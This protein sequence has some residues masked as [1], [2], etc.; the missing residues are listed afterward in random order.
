M[1]DAQQRE[2]RA[3]ASVDCEGVSDAEAALEASLS[4]S[5]DTEHVALA[6]FYQEMFRSG[7][8]RLHLATWPTQ[9]NL[10][11]LAEAEERLLIRGID[12]HYAVM[13]M[14][15]CPVYIELGNGRVMAKIAYGCS[16]DLEDIL[17]RLRADIPPSVPQPGLAIPFTFW[18]LAEHGP[19]A[20]T[21][22][23]EVPGWSD[24]R[25]NYSP[26]TQQA[27]ERLV[28]DFKPARGGQ[29]LLLSGEPGTG[30]TFALRALAWEW[31]HWCQFEYVTD[32]EQF[33][34]H[35]ARYLLHVLLS[36]TATEDFDGAGEKRWRVLLVEDAGELL[37]ADA[38]ERAGQGLSRLLNVVDGLLGQGLKVL[39]LIT[40]NE[41]LG[42]LHPAVSRPGRCAFRYEF[43]RL[44]PEQA[45][46]WLRERGA[47]H[48]VSVPTTIAELYALAEGYQRPAE[49]VMGFVSP[50]ST[51]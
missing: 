22:Q 20:A 26:R 17:R 8:R 29:L 23:I 50:A 45:N 11:N 38:K 42:Q 35:E 3:N 1:D 14:R 21:R 7:C 16:E 10:P 12:W 43:D 32:P 4:G 51:Q 36:G 47:S 27:L 19:W 40:T 41:P 33:F 49:R 18:T 44:P 48:P 13:R 5:F 24:I 2:R 31:R 34:S 28:H 30:K 9:A 25:S 15:G 6:L 37:S 46:A 39:V